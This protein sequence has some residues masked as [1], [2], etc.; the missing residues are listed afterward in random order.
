[1]AGSIVVEL[2]RDGQVVGQWQIQPDSD[3]GTTIES[4][5]AL[6]VR[7]DPA[8]AAVRAD[9]D[10][11]LDDEVTEAPKNNRL[12]DAVASAVKSALRSD[13]EET[14]VPKKTKPAYPADDFPTVLDEE[15]TVGDRTQLMGL[16]R[17]D[18]P[19]VLEGDPE[20]IRRMKVR[21]KNEARGNRRFGK[22]R[23]PIKQEPEVLAEP[24]R[25]ELPGGRMDPETE[26]LALDD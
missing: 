11:I 17:T 9:D 1:M 8:Q 14:L 20:S 5:A 22:D 4:G 13:Q 16:D 6:R 21:A 7:F 18:D 26:E 19:T 25:K 2:V 24:E 23:H 12:A 15:S 10:L 3:I